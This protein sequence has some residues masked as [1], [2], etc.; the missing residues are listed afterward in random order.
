MMEDVLAEL[1]EKLP[2]KN[3]NVPEVKTGYAAAE[4]KDEKL[5]SKYIYPRLQKFFKEGDC[6]IMETGIIPHGF[7][8]I[9]L[10]DN[11]MV[12]TQTLWGSIGWAT[13]AAFGASVALKGK[14]R[15][16]LFT[17][18]GSHQLTASEISNIMRH[19]LNTIVIVLNNDGYTIE[20]IL[21]NSPDDDFNNIIH[22][23]YSKLPEVFSGNVWISQ[24]KT[25]KE[26]NTALKIAETQKS[27]CYLE[28]FTD[29]MDIPVITE[30][31]I[32]KLKKRKVSQ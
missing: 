11:V 13:P 32:E 9:K 4:I 19:N 12:H 16:I 14:R 22:W 10:P 1:I 24:A 15:V 23:N 6:L 26:F 8:K 21:S 2:K 28:I 3:I 20:R 29:E 25:D 18:D 31:T 17:G 30:K 7:A 27:M 5:T